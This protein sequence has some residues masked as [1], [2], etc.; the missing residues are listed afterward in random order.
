L[1]LG[2]HSKAYKRFSGF[3]PSIEY[4][5]NSDEILAK[6]AF[7]GKSAVAVKRLNFL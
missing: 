5:S 7:G 1:Y 4:Q 2:S 6:L 3:A